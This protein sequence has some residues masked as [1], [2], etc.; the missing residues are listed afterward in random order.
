GKSGSPHGVMI[1]HQCVLHRLSRQS[2][3]W[4]M[5]QEDRVALLF[6]QNA[7]SAIDTVFGALTNGASIF[8]YKLALTDADD[9]LKK[10]ETDQISYMQLAPHDLRQ[11]MTQMIDAPSLQALRL[12]RVI[13]DSVYSTDIERF[14]KLFA[15]ACELHVGFG[16]T[17]TGDLLNS[18]FNKSSK[19]R[20]GVVALDQLDKGLR[21]EIR[22]ESGEPTKDGEIGELVV[23]GEYLFSGYWGYSKRENQVLF[24]DENSTSESVFYTGDLASRLPN[25]QLEWVGRTDSQIKIRGFRVEISEVEHALLGTPGISL[26]AVVVNETELGCRELVAFLVPEKNVG[27]DE[28]FIRKQLETVLP[29]VMIPNLFLQVDTLP[30]G[31]TAGAA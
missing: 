17:E 23:K 3:G 26:A 27:I 10:L 5:R 7:A 8:S 20:F 29:E 24:P 28:E 13:G 2:E 11:L 19:C 12:V 9:V 4:G 1:S 31:S 6:P 25:G 30:L 16:C 22:N 14:Q 21:I 18:V 15:E